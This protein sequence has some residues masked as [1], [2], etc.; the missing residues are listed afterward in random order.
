MIQI[1]DITCKLIDYH[2]WAVNANGKVVFNYLDGHPQGGQMQQPKHWRFKAYS[3]ELVDDILK[4]NDPNIR[5][6]LKQGTC[7][8]ATR[9][10]LATHQSHKLVIGCFGVYVPHMKKVSWIFGDPRYSSVD[11]MLKCNLSIDP[12]WTDDIY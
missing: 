6:P 10:Y 11:E 12:L 5:I 3:T 8:Q 1:G 2:A 7:L 9:D 4:T